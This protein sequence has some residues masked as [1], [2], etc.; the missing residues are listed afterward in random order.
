[1]LRAGK[2]TRPFVPFVLLAFC[3]SAKPQETDRQPH[4]PNG[5]SRVANAEGSELE[6]GNLSRVAASPAQIQDVLVNAPGILVELKRWA[7]KEATDNGQIVSDEDLTDNAIFERLKTDVAFRSVATRLVQRYGYLRPSV[8]PASELGKEQDLLLRERVRRLVQIEALEDS[9]S[10]KPLPAQTSEAKVAP[11]DLNEDRECV[12]GA[13]SRLRRASSTPEENP[14]HKESPAN[15]SNEGQPLTSSPRIMQTGVNPEGASFGGAT[16]GNLSFQSVSGTMKSPRDPA[17][18][19]NGSPDHLTAS[20]ME[21]SRAE[22]MRGSATEAAAGE[23]TFSPGAKS[24]MGAGTLGRREARL[25]KERELQP[26][27]MVRQANPYA[28]IPSL[29]DL[30]VQAPAWDRPPQRFGTQIFQDGLRDLRSIPMDLPVGPDYVVG[31]GDSLSIDLWGGVSTKL[32]RVVD[33]QGRVTLP[34]AGPLLVSGRSLGE[35]QQ[36]VQTAIGTQYRD[37]SADV[38]VSRLRTVR[39]YVVGEVEEPGAYDISS[40]STALNAL[41]A[42]G[43]A[44]PRGSL[45]ALK[46]MRGRQELEE[47]DA[48]DLLLHGVT[49]DAKRLENGDTLLVPPPGAQ[50]TVTGMVRRPAIYELNGEKT[51]A[52]VLELA[53][54]ILPAAALRHVEVQ[55]LEAHEKRTMLSLDLSLDN[56]TSSQLASFRIQDGD[57]IHIFPIAPYNQDTI[58]LQGHVLRPGRYSYREGMKLTDLIATYKEILPEPAAH[59][60]EIIRLNPPDFRPSVVSFDLAAAMKDPTTAPQ[61]QPLD[62]VRVFSRY[63]FEAAPAIRVSG[64]VRQPGRY[65]IPGQVHLRDA[66]YLAGGLT[67]DAAQAD[68]QVFRTQADGT[69]KILSVDLKEAMAGNAVENILLLPRDH[70]LIHKSPAKVDPATVYVKGEVAKPGRYPLAA[71]MRVSDLVASAGGLLRSANP[72]SGDLT[73]YAISDSSGERVQAGHQDLSVAAALAGTENQN[74]PLRDGDVLTVPQQAGWKDVGAVVTLRGEVRKPGVYG[75][76][77]GE[78]LSSLLQRAGG[79]LPTAYPR[80]AVFE[81]KEVRE[82]QEKNRQEMIQRLEQE[83]AVVKTAASTTGTEEAALQ[84]AAVQQRQRVLEGLR[85]APVSGRLVIHLRPDRAGFEGSPDDIELRAGDSLMIPKQPGAVLV[86]GQVYN[87]NALTYTPGKSASWYLSRAGGAT[88]LANKGA[89]FIVRSDGSVTSGSQG[90]FW[91]GGVLSATMGP[92][93]TIVVPERAVQGS[94]TLKN[95]LTIAQIASSAALVAAVAIP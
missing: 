42:A 46:H 82:L 3:V 54:G 34:E 25:A 81:R 39:V 95:I 38:S 74:V 91:S 12:Q 66:L 26:G 37:T 59:Y 31:P 93:D 40:L 1:M 58:Y 16:D 24:E 20:S 84:Q 92:G 63:D 79:L 36:A 10:V 60:A 72:D 18:F 62:T 43:G 75:I 17:L 35:V 76:R 87:A 4:Q 80:A 15:D 9:E 49:P 13:A 41:V 64:E 53:G 89:I 68:A 50:V 33:R 70:L 19:S 86:I 30:Y 78:R 73:H 8:N 22:A 32:V 44:T 5:A 85:N 21:Q 23:S 57:E 27:A 90:R 94:T 2:F 51:V 29:Y 28:D 65:G 56:S 45:R 14:L 11:C 47:I 77:S 83:S 48:Y 69:M 7:A 88:Q 52:E 55:R 61:L 71:N 67:P 6:N